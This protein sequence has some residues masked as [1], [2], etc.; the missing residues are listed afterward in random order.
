MP[1]GDQSSVTLQGI[2]VPYVR[3][4]RGPTLLML[5]GGGGPVAAMPFAD[6]LAE[7]FEVIAPVHPG[8]AGTRIPDR[9]DD[10]HDLKFLYLDFLDALDIRDAVLMGF[11]MGGWT[12]A[13]IAVMTTERLRKLILVDAVG[14][15]PGDRDTRDIADVFATP[16]AELVKLTWHDPAK[17]PDIAALDDAGL[18]IVA[19]NRVAL[20]LYTWDPYM[21]DPKLPGLLHRVKVPTLLIWGESD[22]LV[23]PAYGEAYRKLIPDAR[24]V[25]IPKAGHAPQAEQPEAFV[26][27]VLAFAA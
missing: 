26:E 17:A 1:P 11:S 22:R 8:F 9:F 10:I 25:V 7:R 3:K 13:E 4:G 16:P 19:S 18:A 27:H 14:I 23:T 21:Y 5:H 24:L 20:A 12:A 6:R 2:E 15:K